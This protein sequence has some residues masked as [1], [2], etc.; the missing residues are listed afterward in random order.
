MKK[1][2][3]DILDWIAARCGDEAL[4]AQCHQARAVSRDDTGVGV[5]VTLAVPESVKKLNRPVFAGDINS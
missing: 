1:I 3:R 5:F 2:E 4:A